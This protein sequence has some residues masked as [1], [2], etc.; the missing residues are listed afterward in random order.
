MRFR[1]RLPIEII[2][3][4][5]LKETEAALAVAYPG[6]I[7]GGSGVR[8]FGA[9]LILGNGTRHVRVALGEGTDELKPS[10]AYGDEER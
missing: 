3:V 4:V 5:S 1:R 9:A 7:D 10:K 2:V 8:Q 6:F